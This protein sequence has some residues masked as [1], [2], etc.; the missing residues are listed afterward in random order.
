MLNTI[1]QNTI[2]YSVDY[3]TIGSYCKSKSAVALSLNVT[4]NWLDDIRNF[5]RNFLFLS[6]IV[7][8][9]WWHSKVSYTAQRQTDPSLEKIKT[10]VDGVIQRGLYLSGKH[11]DHKTIL[12]NINL[13]LSN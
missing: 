8:W 3:T 9:T 12:A 4:H 13:D 5:C 7:S 11:L 2:D 10:T 6:L 1:V